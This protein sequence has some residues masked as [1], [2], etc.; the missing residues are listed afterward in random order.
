MEVALA[1]KAVLDFSAYRDDEIKGRMFDFFGQ[2]V[3]YFRSE[4]LPG[5][6]VVIHCFPLRSIPP[7]ARVAEDESHDG[8][9]VLR[10][11]WLRSVGAE[12]FLLL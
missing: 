12:I 8:W 5:A 4:S 10:V 6:W 7:P 2:V 1:R 11:W 9:E 3:S